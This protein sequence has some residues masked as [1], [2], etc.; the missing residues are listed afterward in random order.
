MKRIFLLLAGLWVFPAAVS[1]QAQLSESTP[2]VTLDIH[3]VTLP[4]L[5]FELE[6][7]TGMFFSYES[8]LAEDMPLVSLKAKDEPLSYCLKRLFAPLPITYRITGQ[9]IILK[10]KPRQYTISGFVRDSASYESLINAAVQDST[11][12]K[13]TISNSYGFYSI[14]LPAGKVTL[15]SSYVGY[16][17]QEITLLLDKDTL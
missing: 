11:L 4:D 6:K 5:F 2:G 17:S 16:K 8:S 9:Y 14:T 1:L 10:R 15:R 7:Q 13:G 12:G 3:S